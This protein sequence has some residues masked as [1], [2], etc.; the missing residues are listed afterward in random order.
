LR[1]AKK[2]IWTS[3]TTLAA[4][5]VKALTTPEAS[6][7]RFLITDGVYDMQQ[8]ADILHG[9]ATIPEAAKKRI[10]VGVPEKR[11][12]DT[13]YKADKRKAKKILGIESPSLEETVIE[14]AQQLLE[15]EKSS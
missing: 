3:V 12:A 7:E 10:P 14:L 4:S 11:L 2:K 5:H 15:F 1:H 9:V 13:H 6:N 8:L